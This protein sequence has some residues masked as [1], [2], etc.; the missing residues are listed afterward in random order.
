MTLHY[1]PSLALFPS[2][3][4]P[5][6]FPKDV[7]SPSVP[8]SGQKTDGPKEPPTIFGGR[9]VEEKPLWPSPFLYRV[10]VSACVSR[11]GGGGGGGGGGGRG[12]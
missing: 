5:L 11:R 9:A 10:S 3:P 8:L 6:F 2:P 7:R 1:F 12:L 4:L